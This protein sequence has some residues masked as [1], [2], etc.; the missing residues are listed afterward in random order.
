MAIRNAIQ[1]GNISQSIELIN[2]FDPDILDT[3]PELYFSLQLQQLIELYESIKF[4]SFFVLLF[5]PM[6]LSLSS[7]SLSLSQLV[8]LSLIVKERLKVFVFFVL[9]Q[10]TQRKR[11]RRVTIR[12]RGTRTS[13]TRKRTFQLSIQSHNTQ[14]QSHNST[15]PQSHNHTITQSQSQPHNH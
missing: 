3:N 14:S 1:E 6:R 11:C 7:L 2:D 9:T 10:N 4:K 13:W 8:K 15:I 12:S 5:Q